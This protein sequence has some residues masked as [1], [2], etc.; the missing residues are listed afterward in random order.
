MSERLRLTQIEQNDAY[1]VIE[2]RDTENTFFYVDPPY[3]NT[4]Q[5]HYGGY[6]EAHFLHDLDVLSKIK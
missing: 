6:T 5:G 3:I 1:K 2:S 4:N